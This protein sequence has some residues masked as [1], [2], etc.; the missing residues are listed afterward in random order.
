MRTPR[1]LSLSVAFAVCLAVSV[2]SAAERPAGSGKIDLRILYAGHPGSAREKD[3]VQFL[4]EHFGEVETGDLKGFQKGQTAGFDVA[5]L[6]YDGD[7]FKA[8]QPYLT[9]DYAR[10]TVTVGVVGAFICGRSGLKTGYL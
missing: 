3:F 6:D 8:P 7:G 2:C 5:I 9:E 1:A 4:R 10:P